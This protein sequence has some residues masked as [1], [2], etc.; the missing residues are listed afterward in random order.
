MVFCH[1]QSVIQFEVSF[2]SN[3]ILCGV[4]DV[5]FDIFQAFRIFSESCNT[6]TH[7]ENEMLTVS[8]RGSSL[9]ICFL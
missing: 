1:E 2:F 7:Q 3:C 9:I 6:H 8:E 4:V 5:L